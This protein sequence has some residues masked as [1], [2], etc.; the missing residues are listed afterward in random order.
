MFA[1]LYIYKYWCLC[2]YLDI[3]KCLNMFQYLN[4][5]MCI[6][7]SLSIYL[8][9]TEWQALYTHPRMMNYIAPWGSS[10]ISKGDEEMNTLLQNVKQD[11]TL[12]EPRLGFRK[13]G[14]RN[15]RA[16]LT[17][18]IAG[19]CNLVFML[20][21]LPANPRVSLALW[22]I[23]FLFA[24]AFSLALALGLTV[25]LALWI[26]CIVFLFTACLLAPSPSA[27]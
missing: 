14:L 12:R 17:I 18:S 3:H 9:S 27:N 25:S 4:Y 11:L 23:G 26:G 8:T 22:W 21:L 7:I 13:R 10:P 20:H 6:S 15:R 19:Q 2:A 16:A 24:C 5:Y 1:N